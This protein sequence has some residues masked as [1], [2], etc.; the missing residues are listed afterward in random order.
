MSA[1]RVWLVPLTIDQIR[2]LRSCIDSHLYEH[3]SNEGWPVNSG[4]VL[5]PRLDFERTHTER[6]AQAPLT[7]EE[8]AIVEALDE[9]D[10]LDALLGEFDRA[11]EQLDNESP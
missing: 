5:D 8:A 10:A 9:H 6:K 11:D 4:F 3:A 1:E 2:L 7:E